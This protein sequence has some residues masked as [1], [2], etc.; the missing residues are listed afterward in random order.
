MP[1]I[2]MDPLSVAASIVTIL[3]LAFTV[4]E[5]INDIKDAR[6]ERIRLRDEITSASG[7]LYMLRDR[8]EQEQ[9][10]MSADPD[11]PSKSWMSS[12]MALASPGGPL[13][14]F[15][16]ALRELERHLAPF[17]GMEKQRRNFRKSLTWPFQRRNVERYISVIERKKSLFQLA[18]QSDNM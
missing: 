15:E 9:M 1:K 7:P 12:F 5:Y 14:Q 11:G 3:G 10:R 4:V 6:Q 18:L 13:E 2:A 16:R 17:E 8:I